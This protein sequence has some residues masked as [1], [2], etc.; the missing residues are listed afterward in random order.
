MILYQLFTLQTLS[1]KIED[2]PILLSVLPKMTPSQYVEFK[3]LIERC[4]NKI[5]E[6]RPIFNDIISDLDTIFQLQSDP[7][8]QFWTDLCGEKLECKWESF[9]E[10]FHNRFLKPLE[11]Q[12]CASEGQISSQ[13][14]NCLNELLSGGS[15]VTMEQ[16]GLFCNWFNWSVFPYVK[17]IIMV[18]RL[19]QQNYF[20]G[21]MKPNDAQVK[22]NFF[23]T[24]K[25]LHRMF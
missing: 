18:S 9:Y 16:W 14:K 21:A 8:R 6:Q 3:A 11:Q 19:C 17:S 10:L 25:N 2:K 15:I 22:K 4:W 5:I 24:R 20:Q 12:S 1:G 23:P 13:T 7:N